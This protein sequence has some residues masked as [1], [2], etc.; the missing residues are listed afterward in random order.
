L[1]IER[2]GKIQ[3]LFDKLFGLVGL[4]NQGSYTAV[5]FTDV[6]KFLFQKVTVTDN[7]THRIAQLVGQP[8]S[9][10]TQ[11]GQAVFGLKFTAKPGKF[12]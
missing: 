5:G 3:E 8:A 6:F 12:G 11:G 2:S 7:G 4:L 1:I 9:H 10:L